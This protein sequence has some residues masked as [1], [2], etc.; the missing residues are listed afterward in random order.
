LTSASVASPIGMMQAQDKGD[1]RTVPPDAVRI[2]PI[3]SVRPNPRNHRIGDV[4]AITESLSRFGQVRPIVVRD[5]VI[6]AGNHTWKAA[7][8]LGWNEIAV[9]EFTGSEADALAYS[10]ADNRTSDLAM[11]DDAALLDILRELAEADELY[12]TAFDGDDVDDLWRRVDPHGFAEA[13]GA[14]TAT[15]PTET[16]TQPS[17]ILRGAVCDVIH[18]LNEAPHAVVT[19]ILGP[20]PGAE[21]WR[22]VLSA[23]REDCVLACVCPR[24]GSIPE[25]VAAAG[26]HPIDV[27]A[28]VF[29]DE[30]VSPKLPL[31]PVWLPVLLYHA[32]SGSLQPLSAPD[33]GRPADAVFDSSETTEAVERDH[34][35][36]DRGAPLGM[37]VTAL[38]R[39]PATGG[40]LRS[41]DLMAYLMRLTSPPDGLVLDP[42]CTD[43][44]TMQAAQITGRRIVRI[45]PPEE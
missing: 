10:V 22:C 9:V 4:G 21:V 1:S 18:D 7:M 25:S 2:V 26:W 30:T 42:V 29:R 20:D 28:F 27:L 23:V 31:R 36:P 33:G 44:A 8:A 34:C 15:A 6:I 24:I 32:G 3:D 43:D 40:A 16:K 38:R 37:V 35:G 45:A 41:T 14:S 19:H 5:G 39:T 17:A 12:G 13:I 11:N